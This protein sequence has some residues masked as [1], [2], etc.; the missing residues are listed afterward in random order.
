MPITPERTRFVFTKLERELV[1]L[2]S[3]RQ[4]ES[5]HSFRTG[6]RR[7]QTE[8]ARTFDTQLSVGDILDA[9][10]HRAHRVRGRDIV[11]A[12]REAPDVRG[13]L[14]ERRALELMRASR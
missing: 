11:L 2:S 9:D 10:A 12:V 8:E 13:A 6:T 5:V 3:E 1:T 7:L 4:P 14:A